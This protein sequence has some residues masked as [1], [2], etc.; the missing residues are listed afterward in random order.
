[1]ERDKRGRFVKKYQSGGTIPN[2]IIIEGKEIDL[3][4]WHQDTDFQNLWN[5]TQA[6]HNK[7]KTGQS[8]EEYLNGVDGSQDTNRNA[9][10]YKLLNSPHPK[11]QKPINWTGIRPFQRDGM[12]PIPN[13]NTTFPQSNEPSNTDPSAGMNTSDEKNNSKLI[14]K[15][16][17]SNTLELLRSGIGYATNNRIADR[18]IAAEKP[19]LQNPLEHYRPVYGNYRAQKEGQQSA[20]QLRN[21]ASRPIT[22]DGALQSQMQMEAQ[23]KGNQFISEG[24]KQDENLI[25]QTNEVAWQQDKENAQQ[26]HA[27]AEANRKSMFMTDKNKMSIENMRDS[28]NYTQIIAPLLAA[29]EQRMRSDAA[30]RD[31]Y[32]KNLQLSTV[33]QEVWNTYNEGLTDQQ[34]ELRDAYLSKG[35]AGVQELKGKDVTYGTSWTQLLQLMNNEILKRSASIHGIDYEMPTR[36]NYGIFSKQGGII[37]KAKLTARAKDNDRASKSIAT[38]RKIAAKFLEKAMDS[39]YTYKDVELIAKPINKKKQKYQAGGGLPF[40]GFTPVFAT[41]E[42]GAPQTAASNDTEN[43]KG[44]DLTNKDVLELLKELDGLPTDIAMITSEL[45]NFALSEQ[46]DP[47]GLSSTNIASR[48]INLISKIQTAKFNKDEYNTAFNQLKSNGGLNE[49][50][51]TSEGYVIGTKDGEFNYFTPN[52][53]NKGIPQQQGY[54]ILTN[55]NL[56]YLRANSPD[57]A[58]N[59]HLTTI[60]QNGIGMKVITEQ[61]NTIIQNLGSNKESEQGFVQIGNS[62]SIK[63]GL[64]FLQK[65]AQKVGDSSIT[66]NM[67]IADYYQAGYLTEDQAQQAQ[68]AITYIW[69]SLSENAKSL[70]QVKGGSVEGALSLV[71]SL[72]N[73]KT[74]ITKDFKATPKKM[75]GDKAGSGSKSNDALNLTPVQMMQLGYTDRIDVTLQ[76]GTAYATVIRNAQVLPITDINKSNIGITTLDDV[77]KST[78]GGALDMNHISMGNQAIEPSATQNI[79]IDGTN[80]Y[81]VNLPIDKSSPDGTIKPDLVYLKKIE[82]I[83]QSIQQ[84]GITDIAEINKIYQEAGLPLLLNGDGSLNVKDYCKFGVL[85]GKALSRAFK[86]YNA[87]DDTVLEIEDENTIKDVL[88]ILNKGRSEKD[89]LDFDSKSIWDSILFFRDAGEDWETLVE[90]TI[91]IPVRTNAFTGM[92][93]GGSYPDV[94]T[95]AEVEA[96]MQQQQR[97]STYKDP[98]L[99]N[100]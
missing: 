40:V 84:Q 11:T 21:L 4:P 24:N 82:A 23:L 64:Q 83:N 91:Y 77:A 52:D 61:I 41:S 43:K 31:A 49:Y 32:L 78:F 59:H 42:Q 63:S 76:R 66:D 90:G 58:F 14:N 88:S 74:S 98:G 15:I 87:L 5:N 13:I 71:Q 2:K 54:S 69:G 16:D 99:I 38:S 48:Y 45:Q 70:L 68:Q 17:L 96:L 7:L 75:S 65:A 79:Q 73:S 72:V 62:N 35:L 60:A 26:R 97:V 1:M 93:G 6:D 33:E 100:D 46:M 30:R 27:V 22:S 57:A 12:M 89:K 28:A 36:S 9:L 44:K 80:L 29:K 47:L 67:S 94:E 85:N 3:T 34:K 39:L 56:L 19:L 92:I 37:Y 55:S 18:A 53:V 20:A 95:A 86:N 10:R 25:R 81:I 8:F 51:I 50:A